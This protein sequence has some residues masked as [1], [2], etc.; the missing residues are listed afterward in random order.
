MSANDL[1]LESLPEEFVSCFKAQREAYVLNRNPSYQ[2]R[3]DDLK[4]LH[5]L[6]VENKEAIIE[7]LNQDYGTRSRYETIFAELLTVQESALDTL[8]HLK[9]WMKPKRKSVNFMLYPFATAR[10]I[11]QPLGV[12]G[13]VVPWNFPITLGINPLI[14]AICAGNRAMIK[15]SEN[16]NHLAHLFIELSPNYLPEDKVKFFEDGGGRGPAFTTLPFDHVFFTGSPTTGRSV[17]ANCAKNLTPVTLELGGKSPTIVAPDFPIELAVERILWAKMFNSGQIC[18]NVDYLFLPEQAVDEFVE[19]AKRLANSRYPD[20]N[21]GDYS[22]II[23]QRSYDRLTSELEDAKKKGAEIIDLFEN[24]AP[25]SEKRIMPL[26]LVLNT[27]DNMEIM[28]R[29]LFGPILPIKTYRDTEEVI[30]YINDRPR[31]LSLYIYTND[32]TLADWYINN[33]MS[34]GVT[35]NDC[36]LHHQQHGLPF[37]GVGNSGMGHYHGYESFTTFSKMRPVFY[38]SRLRPINMLMPPYAGRSGK[39][40]DFLLKMKS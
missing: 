37:G 32:T 16:S 33:T 36:L 39:V 35:V 22:A 14:G 21:N 25:D 31:P 34:G 3:S 4:A 7:A 10:V 8:K 19:I 2:E 13:I 5:R 27:T 40:I 11:P 23:D 20:I 15:M 1:N 12:V 29:E 17:M 6:L 38:Q 9:K 28:Q 26:R 24:Q 18:I 30:N